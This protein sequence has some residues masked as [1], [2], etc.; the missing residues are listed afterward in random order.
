MYRY[1]MKVILLFMLHVNDFGN[2]FNSKNFKNLM[3]IVHVL[4]YLP[5]LF[6]YLYSHVGNV[7]P[8]H[9]IIIILYYIA[10]YYFLVHII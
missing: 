9:A 8:N 2:I 4:I 3:K 1:N 6:E 10:L 7:V 5:N